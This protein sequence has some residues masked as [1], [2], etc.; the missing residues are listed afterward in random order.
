MAK[1]SGESGVKVAR[2][3]F[4]EPQAG[5]S[6]ADRMS[7]FMKRRVRD[8]IDQGNDATNGRELY[9]AMV[10][11]SPLNGISVHY[12]SL[13]NPTPPEEKPKISGI[14]NYYD[15]IFLDSGDM[16][17]WKYYRNFFITIKLINRGRSW[18]YF[19]L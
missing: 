19:Y 4:S 16:V 7:A 2:Y 18:Y 15:F 13:V 12:V 10:S 3:S 9:K 1:L 6:S 5:K 17:A 11:G 14:S 8:Y